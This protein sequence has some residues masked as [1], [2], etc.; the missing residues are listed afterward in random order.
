VAALF[1]VHP[2][3]MA[4]LPLLRRVWLEQATL[5]HLEREHEQRQAMLTAIGKMFGG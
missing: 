1:G 2:W 5:R 4:N 3:Q